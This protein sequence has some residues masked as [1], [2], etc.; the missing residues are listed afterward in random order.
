MNTY[1]EKTSGFDLPHVE[2]DSPTQRILSSALKKT[3][4]NSFLNGKTIY[5][6]STYL[7]LNKVKSFREA[8]V[9]QQERIV[10]IA[11]QD[12]LE[13]IYWVEQAGVGYMAKM[14]MLSETC[15][16]RLLYGLFA[17][18]E[19][20]HL[21]AISQFLPTSP[22]FNEDTFLAYISSLLESPDKLLLMTLIQVILEGWGISHYRY[23]AENCLQPELTEVLRGFL[24]AES[25][26]HALGVT[27]L[28]SCETY[29]SQTLTSIRCAL[30]YFLHMVQI[31]PQRLLNALEMGLGYLS[32][33]D[34][35]KV[36]EELQTELHSNTRL[37]LLRSLMIGNV[38]DLI[39]QSLE[40]QGSFQA[41]PA[42]KCV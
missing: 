23:L 41:Y 31:G 8:T 27:H 19:A 29:P 36:L 39:I 40:E 16:E 28:R 15:E 37:K 30:S 32:I 24:E 12:L 21:S 9:E 34:K 18:D 11:N 35:I 22:V 1:S 17:A 42:S 13:E 4:L 20:T 26:H 7:G 33:N 10:K 5:W 6:D 14:V 2:S 38:P 25:R 3:D